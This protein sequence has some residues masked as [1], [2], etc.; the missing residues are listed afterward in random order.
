MIAR[1]SSE[2]GGKVVF[3]TYRIR[4]EPSSDITVVDAVLATCSTQSF[5]PV[6][7]GA[8]MRRQE[9][10]GWGLGMGNPCR[11]LISE[12][13]SLYGGDS[14]V[15]LIASFGAG[16]TIPITAPFDSNGTIFNPTTADCEQIAQ[17][18]ETQ[19]GQSQFYFRLHVDRVVQEAAETRE[20]TIGTI[21]TRTQ[22]Y[23]SRQDRM[24]DRCVE[25]VK[26]GEGLTTLD[27]IS[28]FYGYVVFY[29]S[30]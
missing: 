22:A 14:R 11:H 26:H 28:T 8:H 12:A 23:L 16:H 25:A 19:L 29:Y 5:S 20:S 24:I 17:E 30:L 3:R 10:V 13:Q 27:Q 15:A 6:S 9:Y 18:M 4:S 21:L 7:F 1:Q 2:I